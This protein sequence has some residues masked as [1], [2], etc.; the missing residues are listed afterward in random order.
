MLKNSFSE[1]KNNSISIPLLRNLTQINPLI[2]ISKHPNLIR[3][4]RKETITH[5]LYKRCKKSY[6]FRVKKSHQKEK[7]DFW[8]SF[9]DQKSCDE[10]HEMETGISKRKNSFMVWDADEIEHFS[11]A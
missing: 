2:S 4:P 5:T 6:S 1:S 3:N 8:E 10:L 7:F 11:H 9:V